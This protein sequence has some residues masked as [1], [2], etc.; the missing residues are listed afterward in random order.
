MSIVANNDTNL[1]TKL[2]ENEQNKLLKA[3]M[4]TTQ[5]LD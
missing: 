3:C 5:T 4:K 2:H 1:M